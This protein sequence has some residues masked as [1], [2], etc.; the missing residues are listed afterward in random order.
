MSLKC[1]EAN[2]RHANT[3]SVWSKFLDRRIFKVMVITDEWKYIFMANGGREQLFN[4]RRDPNELSN[5]VTSSPAIKDGLYAL[6]VKAMPR[7]G[8]K[9]RARWRQTSRIP[10]PETDANAHLSIRPVARRPRIP[11]ETRS[12][13]ERFRPRHFES[14]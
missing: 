12:R 6:A 14:D 11:R 5:C 13:A 7:P 3:S 8:R 2:A 1:F 4:R 9:R 10:L